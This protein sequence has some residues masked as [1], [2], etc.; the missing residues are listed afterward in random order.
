MGTPEFAVPSLKRIREDGHDIVAVVTAPDKRQGRGLKVR[1]SAVKNAAVSLGVERILQPTSVK[2]PE[3]AAQVASLN[4][5]VIVVV[6]FR[7][8]PPPVFNA[9][10]LGSFNLHGSLLPKY[11][12]AAPI[13]HAVLSGD[14]ETGVTTFFLKQKVDTGN[15]IMRLKMPIGENETTGE[16]YE[17]M[18]FL[19]AEAVSKTLRL[20]EDGSAAVE[21]QDDSLAS[22]APKVHAADA[23]INWAAGSLVVHNQIRGYSP[24][25]GAWST[26]RGQ[27]VKVFRSLRSFDYGQGDPPGTIN[28]V[29]DRLFVSCGS[30]SVEL[31]ELQLEGKKRVAAAD[32]VRGYRVETGEVL[33]STSPD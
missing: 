25:P 14:S 21:P 32:F 26:I 18:M 33:K 2:D 27:R 19:G 13:H 5:D 9:A 6:A 22:P 4:A 1:P 11:R 29:E 31:L 28:T 10:H 20:I 23:A 8:L 3:F 30:G 17:R 15:V 24:I 12:G 16:V 7:I